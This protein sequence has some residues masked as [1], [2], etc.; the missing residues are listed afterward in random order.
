MQA[1]DCPKDWQDD[2]DFVWIG[3]AS[4]RLG[5]LKSMFAPCSAKK[6]SG[7]EGR[8]L[9]LENFR[10]RLET[11]SVLRAQAKSWLPGRRLVCNCGQSPCHGETIVEFLDSQGLFDEEN[12]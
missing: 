4:K 7:D 6:N 2:Y 12:K 1:K 5:V 11:I 10:K 3:N 8:K 9:S